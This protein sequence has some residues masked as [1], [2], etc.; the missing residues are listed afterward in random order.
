MGTARR[1][2]VAVSRPRLCSEIDR[3]VRGGEPPAL[4]S[5]TDIRAHRHRHHPVRRHPRHLADHRHHRRLQPV[6]L[7]RLGDGGQGRQRR[8]AARASWPTGCTPPGV[9][10]SRPAA[11]S[12]AVKPGRLDAA[13]QHHDRV[14]ADERRDVVLALLARLVRRHHRERA[15]D[16][17][18]GD[19]DPGG[20]RPRDGARHTGHDLA[21]HARP[22]GTPPAPRCRGRRRTDRRP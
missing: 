14:H 5:A 12:R 20:R 18:R 8:P 9:S 11:I 7:G 13:H 1:R 2:T 6:P 19:R 22:R 3:L 10:G 15:R 4:A 21:P 17:A 16:A